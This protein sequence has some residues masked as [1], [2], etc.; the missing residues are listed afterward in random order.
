MSYVGVIEIVGLTLFTAIFFALE[1]K[2]IVLSLSVLNLFDLVIY[3]IF[4]F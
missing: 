2:K 3:I 1:G 4:F